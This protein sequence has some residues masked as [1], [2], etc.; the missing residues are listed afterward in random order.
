M[1]SNLAVKRFLK[2]VLVVVVLLIIALAFGLFFAFGGSNPLLIHVANVIDMLLVVM[3]VL[4]LLA[5]VYW[6]YTMVTGT[7]QPLTTNRKRAPSRSDEDI[8]ELSELIDN[9]DSSNT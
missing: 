4:F 2:R 7:G 6:L 1:D 5:V 3:T 8:P 9:L